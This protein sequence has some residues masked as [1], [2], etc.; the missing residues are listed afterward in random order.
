MNFDKEKFS[1]LAQ[2]AMIYVTDAVLELERKS[3]LEGVELD[4]ASFVLQMEKLEKVN[5]NL[6]NHKTTNLTPSEQYLSTMVLLKF[7]KLVCEYYFELKNRKELADSE[8]KFTNAMSNLKELTDAY[9]IAKMV[10]G[11]LEQNMKMSVNQLI[12]VYMN[13]NVGK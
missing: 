1:Q 6:I 13:E 5:L 3:V 4:L 11:E 8:N 2:F 7:V 12:D 9:D 10:V